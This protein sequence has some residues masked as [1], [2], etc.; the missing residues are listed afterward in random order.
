MQQASGIG[1]LGRQAG[2][3]IDHFVTLYASLLDGHGAFQAEDLLDARLIGVTNE[4]STGDQVAFFDPTVPAVNGF[5]LR[6]GL[7]YNL[8]F[9]E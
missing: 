4:G 2:D 9:S 8:R 3:A 5:G 6:Q 7:G 1:A